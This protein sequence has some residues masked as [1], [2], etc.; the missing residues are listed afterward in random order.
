MRASR[1]RPT[2]L[3][4]ASGERGFALLVVL[5][6]FIVLF[7]VGAEFSGAM[8]QGA[9]A[10]MNFAGE[11]QSYYLAVAVANR[12]F[13]K[14]LTARDEALLEID[15]MDVDENGEP[16][17]PLIRVDGQWYSEPLW[18]APVWIRIVDESGKV[19]LNLVN[20]PILRYLL[21][22]FGLGPEDADA[23]AAAILDWRDKDD[24]ER[25][26]GAE[27]D[28]YLSLSRPYPAKNALFDSLEELLLVR[29]ISWDLFHGGTEEF[30]VGLKQVFTVYSSEP[31]LNV[32][33][34]SRGTLRILLGLDDEQTAEFEELRST[35]PGG[36]FGLIETM[37]SEPAL[38][39]LLTDEPPNLLSIEVQ[40]RL[41]DSPV[42]AHVGAI[43]DLAESHG[44]YYIVRWFDQL[45]AARVP[46]APVAF[47]EAA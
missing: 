18:G 16:K 33:S 34:A 8:R 35:A 12:T 42:A 31:A 36:I 44:G 11:T 26:N 40:A 38:L 4:G 17:K 6:I 23:T 10:T 22:N 15:P 27:T 14:A 45:P 2:G 28:H 25:V 43:I 47:P 20:E 21:R 19:P 7:A 9:A 41:P 39:D 29:G 13:Y 24:E 46:A 32:R 5:W 30:P 1:Q 37:V 3:S